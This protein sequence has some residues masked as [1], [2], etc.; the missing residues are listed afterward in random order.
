MG[1]NTRRAA[2]VVAVVVVA[3]LGAVTY[4]SRGA[5]TLDACRLVS[6][7]LGERLLGSST[8]RTEAFEPDGA[9]DNDTGCHLR[10]TDGHITVFAIPDGRRLFARTPHFEPA[11]IRTPD[12]SRAWYLGGANPVVTV[13]AGRRY[14]QITFGDKRSFNPEAVAAEL[15]RTLRAA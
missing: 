11:S 12:G 6:P 5:K 7:T 2:G 14:V 9:E 15:A 1:T 8:F 10:S 4:L 13:L 3:A